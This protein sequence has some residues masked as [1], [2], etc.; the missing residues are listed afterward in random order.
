MDTSS[1][2]AIVVGSMSD[3]GTFVNV[4]SIGLII[5]SG[6]GTT[7]GGRVSM[8]VLNS[9]LVHNFGLVV[10]DGPASDCKSRALCGGSFS[11]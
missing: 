8:F 9:N 3:G 5:D 6:P 1:R 10:G 7:W 2:N 11:A 4:W